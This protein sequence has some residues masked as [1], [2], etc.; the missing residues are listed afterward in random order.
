M[1]DFRLPADQTKEAPPGVALA[2]GLWWD[3]DRRGFVDAVKKAERPSPGTRLYLEGLTSLATGRL[4]EAVRSFDRLLELD[5][6]F[7]PARLYRG[8]ALLGSRDLER[9]RRDLEGAKEGT[10]AFAE[11]WISL[12]QLAVLDGDLERA[13]AI[14]QEGRAAGVGGAEFEEMDGWILRSRRGP[15]WTKRFDAQGKTGSVASDHSILL[16]NDV[17][18][19]L[20]IAVASCTALFPKTTRPSAPI[21]VYVFSSRE[22]FLNYAGDLG[23]KLDSAAGAYLPRVRE[24]VLFVPPVSREDLWG[25]VR[26]EGFHAFLHDLVA[27]PPPWFDEGWAQCMEHGKVEFGTIRMT[28]LGQEDRDAVAH[29]VKTEEFLLMDHEQFMKNAK[30]NY[31]LCRALVTFLFT[32]EKPR[33]RERLFAFFESLR[34]GLSAK[35]AYEKD[36]KPVIGELHAAFN[37]WLLT[38]PREDGK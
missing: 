37:V 22:G 10:K 27:E 38:Q 29:T 19:T 5:P 9:A 14:L 24:L 33:Y 20:D 21:R 4:A 13:R 7:A 12:A 28:P 32:S 1:P 34:A 36:F 23:R 8:M 3:G 30:I 15:P 17:C 31:P 35:E 26:H 25:T 2:L 11:L 18:R 16:C 6:A